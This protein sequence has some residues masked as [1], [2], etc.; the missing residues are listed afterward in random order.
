MRTTGQK[1]VLTTGE[2]AEICHVAPRTVS[3]WFDTGKLR[4]YRIPG[5]RDRR[6]PIE[7]LIAF[8]RAYGIPLDELDCGICRVL[9][10]A[11]E[12]PSELVDAI[13]ATNRYDVQ[14]A[15]SGFQAGVLAQQIRPQVVVLDVELAEQECRAICRNIRDS[16]EL[17]SGRIIALGCD[18]N[19]ELGQDLISAGFDRCLAK[20]YTPAALVKVIESAAEMVS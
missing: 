3:K 16:E 12:I 4:G 10:F 17:Q 11:P 6:I 18:E 19:C 5:S 8:M 2:V 1:T 9:V 20:P 13:N 14:A 7:H 15:D